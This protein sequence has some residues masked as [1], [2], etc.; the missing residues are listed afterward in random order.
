MRVV[1]STKLHVPKIK[2]KRK[3]C[4]KAVDVFGF[5]SV[6][7]TEVK[8]MDKIYKTGYDY[9]FELRRANKKLSILL[10]MNILINGLKIV[11]SR[12]KDLFY[13]DCHGGSGAYIDEDKKIFYGSPVFAAETIEKTLIV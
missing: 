12:N 9:F 6:V 8:M 1:R 7:I 13:F 5:E 2:H 10:L 4:I 11:G 3:V